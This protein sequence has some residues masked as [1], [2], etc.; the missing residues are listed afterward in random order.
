M[1]S[2]LLIDDDPELLE[3][4]SLELGEDTDFSILTCSSA[5]EAFRQTGTRK[6]DAIV[7]D[8]YMPG[9]NG[10]SLLKRMREQGSNALHILYSGKGPDAEIHQELGNDIDFYV[11]RR[12]NP[13]AEFRELRRIIQDCG[14]AIKADAR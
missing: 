12:G 5:D 6:F 8:Y 14:S 7:C 13:E 11:Q 10:C 3:I 1:I 9:M 4:T 2:V